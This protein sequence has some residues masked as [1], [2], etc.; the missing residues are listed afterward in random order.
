MPVE[1]LFG[2]DYLEHSSQRLDSKMPPSTSAARQGLEPTKPQKQDIQFRDDGYILVNMSRDVA[3]A[4]AL[5]ALSSIL[6]ILAF[7][8]SPGSKIGSILERGDLLLAQQTQDI[9]DFITKCLRFARKK[10]G[11]QVERQE[12]LDLGRESGHAQPIVSFPPKSNAGPS[13]VSSLSPCKV[14]FTSLTENLQ[15]PTK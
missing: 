5:G 11:L 7:V 12:L 15:S 3:Y 10:F 13:V 9:S 4:P 6:S 2:I 8:R 1:V 14:L